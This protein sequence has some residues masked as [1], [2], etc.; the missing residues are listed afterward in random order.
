MIARKFW[1]VTG[2]GRGWG[3]DLAEAEPSHIHVPRRRRVTHPADA[4]ITGTWGARV[5]HEAY[6]APPV[7]TPVDRSPAE[8]RR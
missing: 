1:F 4:G 3:G 8:A 2:A 6:G 7:E 5:D